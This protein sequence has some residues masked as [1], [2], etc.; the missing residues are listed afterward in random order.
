LPSR[1]GHHQ[2]Q[3]ED[4][5]QWWYVGV[6][7]ADWRAAIAWAIA[8]ELATTGNDGS[9]RPTARGRLL[10]DE[11]FVVSGPFAGGVGTSSMPRLSLASQDSAAGRQNLSD[12]DQECIWLD[13]LG[14]EGDAGIEHAVVDD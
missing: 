10:S 8:G 2:P 5:A 7:H 1:C 13:R 3:P 14:E 4:W 12:L 6:T 11:L 9:V